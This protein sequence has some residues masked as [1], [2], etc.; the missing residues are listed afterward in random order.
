MVD[1][2]TAQLDLPAA[3][4]LL[5]AWFAQPFHH[6]R[7]GN[8]HSGDLLDHDRVMRRD[9]SRGAEA[10]DRSQPQPDDRN[11]GHLI[12]HKVE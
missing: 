9:Q 6:R 3:E 12:C 10:G 4:F 5:G 7:P 1:G 2:A 8:K 11:L